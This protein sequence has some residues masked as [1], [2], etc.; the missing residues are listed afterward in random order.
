M[1]KRFVKSGTIA[2][3]PEIKRVAF[4][5][6]VWLWCASATQ[7][8]EPANELR[9][10]NESVHALIKKVSPSVVQIL[11]TGFGAVEGGEHGNTGE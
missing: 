8:Q 9:K 2:S 7:G 5:T 10:V 1:F 11:V 4:A 6:V 3:K